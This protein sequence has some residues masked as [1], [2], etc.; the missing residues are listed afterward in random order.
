MKNQL[1]IIIGI[2]I[3]ASLILSNAGSLFAMGLNQIGYGTINFTS[4][5][6]K[7]NGIP[8]KD[9]NGV[10]FY[11]P[12]DRVLACDSTRNFLEDKVVKQSGILDLSAGT[13]E[14]KK[15]RSSLMLLFEAIKNRNNPEWLSERSNTQIATLYEL[16]RNVQAT[17]ISLAVKREYKKRFPQLAKNEVFKNEVRMVKNSVAKHS[18]ENLTV[19]VPTTTTVG[20]S[21]ICSGLFCNLDLSNKELESLSGLEMISETIRKSIEGLDISHNK[22]D[23][24]N[25]VFC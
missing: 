6:N 11:A 1:K 21:L 3:F 2:G 9:S 25:F 19:H 22:L 12:K 4:E 5:F 8:I 24:I 20:G 17:P 23:K 16:E 10:V 14:P 7:M 13:T 15:D 18:P